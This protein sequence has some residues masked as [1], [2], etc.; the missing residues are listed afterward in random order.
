MTPFQP[1]LIRIPPE[2]A[3]AMRGL[4]GRTRIRAADHYREA[5]AD[6]LRKYDALPVVPGADGDARGGIR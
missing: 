3:A 4:S 1:V 6:L 5:I 2:F